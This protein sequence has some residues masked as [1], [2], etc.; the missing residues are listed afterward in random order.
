MVWILLVGPS[1]MLD[2]TF[3]IP[4]FFVLY[5]ALGI[6]FP[7]SGVGLAV[8]GRRG[9]LSSTSIRSEVSYK[10]T[11]NFIEYKSYLC[12]YLFGGTGV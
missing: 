12:I 6:L 4:T 7:Q 3:L 5:L 2:P 10:L 9:E 8:R 1:P 11:C